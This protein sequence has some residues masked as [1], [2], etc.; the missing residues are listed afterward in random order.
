VKAAASDLFPVS[1]AAE[2]AFAVTGG[3]T[4]IT[5]PVAGAAAN[6]FTA[7][8]AMFGRFPI[9]GAATND[10]TATA[11]MFG[12]FPVAGT[13]SNGFTAVADLNR[14]AFPIAGAAS[15]GFIAAGMFAS[16]GDFSVSGAASNGFTA[17]ADLNGFAFPV[18]GT[19]S[20][21]FTAVADLNGFAFPVA[22]TA[23]N[24]FTAVGNLV[25]DIPEPWSG[26]WSAAGITNT[27]AKAAINAFH[28]GL[29]TDGIQSK[30]KVFVLLGAE[31]ATA[32]NVMADAYHGALVNSPTFTQWLG[33]RGDATASYI[34]TGTALGSI[35]GV[36][37]NS[38][39]I[40]VGAA[41]DEPAANDIHA[42]NYL[43]SFD[44]P[45]THY[46]SQQ[47]YFDNTDD[48]NEYY[49]YPNVNDDY[50]ASQSTP[51]GWGTL[52]NVRAYSTRTSATALAS[53]YGAIQVTSQSISSTGVP[54]Y[55]LFL[56]A[57][58]NAGSPQ[59]SGPPNGDDTFD[60]K[61]YMIAE[62]LS[63]TEIAD[64][65]ARVV[66]LISALEAIGSN[67]FPVAGAASNE[68]TAVAD[69][70]GF[71]FPV[72]GTA[73]NGFT[74]VADLNEAAG[75]SFPVAGAASNGFTATADLNEIV[76]YPVAGAASNGFTATG[77]LLALGNFTVV[78]STTSTGATF[79]LHGSAQ[80]GDVAV[81]FDYA[82]NSSN[83]APTAVQP[84]GD[85][86]SITSQ[87]TNPMRGTMYARI[88]TSGDISTGT[89]TGMGGTSQ[90]RKICTVFRPT[91]ALASM[92]VRN[93]TSVSTNTNPGALSLATTGV[94]TP[95]IA[96]GHMGA[97]GTID[98][99]TIS[100]ATM[101]E[102]SGAANNHYAHYK[103]YAEGS[104]P[105]TISYDMDDEGSGNMTSIAYLD[106]TLA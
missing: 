89:F 10:F 24:G 82:T 42:P 19:A 46:T 53:Y 72:A 74:A 44:D 3:M 55:A 73:S 17:V 62:G 67:E 84:G 59:F 35:S 34:S 43:A 79:S 9:A 48:A 50:A 99:R 94:A 63:D 105:D 102:V 20:N 57:A 15:N 11:A 41:Q 22:G 78:G 71:A 70:N 92:T 106:F 64:F 101:V 75:D 85:W 65:D 80:A 83:P 51:V 54:D 23:S 96:V 31:S 14:S 13:A 12:R 25:Q 87:T 69:L 52:S 29:A 91:R 27:T 40:G 81:L 32:K 58:N 2:Q 60:A 38:V 56:A 7:T 18:A 39:A 100:G 61:W 21:G 49:I 6:E 76:E 104:S 86:T 30:V 77:N 4:G 88:L 16:I 26:Y 68:F 36:S 5:F 98:P 97:T 93:A 103:I 28:A 66:T 8:A 47:A 33:V 37:Q 90:D 45:D 1:G 95:A